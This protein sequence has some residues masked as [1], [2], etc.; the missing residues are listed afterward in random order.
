MKWNLLA[1]RNNRANI[2]SYL[3]DEEL[4]IQDYNIIVDNYSSEFLDAILKGHSFYVEAQDTT[5][6]ESNLKSR[7]SY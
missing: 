7:N 5:F 2:H 6:M 4:A 1:S 3:G